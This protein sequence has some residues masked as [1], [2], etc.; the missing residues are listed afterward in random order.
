VILHH[1]AGLYTTYLHLSAISV[2]Q[3]QKVERGQQLGKVGK[4]GRVTGPHLH[5]GVK[6][7]GLYV[8]PTALLE[9]EL[10]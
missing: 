9:L 2:Q 10:P 1:G 6:V 4:T 5:W 3:G 8:D 7:D